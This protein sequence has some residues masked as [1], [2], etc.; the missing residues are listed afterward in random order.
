[1]KTSKATVE[2]ISTEIGAVRFDEGA[3]I[4]A[5]DIDEI[6]EAMGLLFGADLHGNLIDVRRMLYLSP[7]ARS[8]SAAQNKASVTGIAVLTESTLQKTMANLY[9][10]VSRPQL[11][12]RLFTDEDEALGWLIEITAERKRRSGPPSSAEGRG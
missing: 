4:E 1:V 3:G 9:L 6:T 8:R 12:T 5:A 2:K 11:P 10:T 7:E